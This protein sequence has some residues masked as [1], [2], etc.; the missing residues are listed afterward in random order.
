MS[1]DKLHAHHDP[2]YNECRAFGQLETMKLNGKV[3]VRCHGYT[4]LP[5]SVEVELE[6]RFDVGEWE[7]EDYDKP[8]T[9][10]AAFRAVVKDLVRD[11]TPLTH[12]VLKK[13][14]KDL[15]LIR[16]QGV[17]P[18]DIK[19]SNYKGG[20]LVDLSNALTEPHYL[21]EIRPKYQVAMYKN[22]DLFQFD[23]MVKAANIKTWLRAMPD[24]NTLRKLR[25]RDYLQEFY[26]WSTSSTKSTPS[27]S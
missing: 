9:K 23:S 17:Y 22:E 10:R 20:L 7:R 12:R 1:L 6:Q 14:K 21:F 18:C 5:P 15:L 24:E 8:V 13:I 16:K 19:A 27:T 2:F 3:A 11:D 4:T 25:K 26:G